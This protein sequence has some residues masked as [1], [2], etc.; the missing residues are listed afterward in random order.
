VATDRGRTAPTVIEQKESKVGQRNSNSADNG[1]WAAAR[2]DQ[3]MPETRARPLLL[4]I[5]Y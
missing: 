3:I 2:R 1:G 4:D 5:A